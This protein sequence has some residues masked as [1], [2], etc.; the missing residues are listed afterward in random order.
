MGRVVGVLGQ[1]YTNWRSHEN[2]VNLVDKG[3]QDLCH[4]YLF[5]QKDITS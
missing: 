2:Q 4:T 3:L 5:S 1:F